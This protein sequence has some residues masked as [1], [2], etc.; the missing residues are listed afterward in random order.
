MVTEFTVSGRPVGIAAGLTCCD[1]D[2]APSLLAG[3]LHRCNGISTSVLGCVTHGAV[4]II[5]RERV[6][7]P[8]LNP[9][10]GTIPIATGLHGRVG[11]LGFFIDPYPDLGVAESLGTPVQICGAYAR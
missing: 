8:A 6:D 7:H 5:K 4:A 1:E 10:R 3:H 2:V 11:R 9:R